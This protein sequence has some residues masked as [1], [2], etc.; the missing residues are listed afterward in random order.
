[1]VSVHPTAIVEAGAELDADVSIGPYAIIG[2]HVKIG[3]RT[4]VGPHCVIGGHTTIGADNRFYAHCAIGGDPQDKKYRDEPTRL[5]IGDRNTI[6]EFCTFST[7]TVQGG[8][9]TR[10]GSD[11]WIMAY[12]HV[13]H[14]CVVGNQV[15]F[16]N[17]TQLAGHVEVGD[18]VILAGF[19]GVHQFCRI[20]AH[21]MTGVATKLVQDVP[22]FVMA[23]GN[24]AAARGLNVEGLRR[25]GFSAD[26]IGHVKRAY[27]ILYRE[28]R[29]LDDAKTALSELAKSTA[30]V[31]VQGFL[32]FVAADGR[33][34]IR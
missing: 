19:T 15:I 1:M 5:D 22:P 26:D 6:R 10:F 4:N 18:W 25:R 24:P 30:S 34:I 3:A 12:V 32:D 33:G 27:K 7:G 31:H 2:P 20:G 28:N 17:C 14:D 21:A 29:L 16:A 23:E 11:N 9:V 13:A 8:G